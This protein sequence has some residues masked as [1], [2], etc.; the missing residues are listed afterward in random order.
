MIE[1][2]E[3]DNKPLVLV[4]GNWNRRKGFK[5][6]MPTPD[7]RIKILLENPAGGF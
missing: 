5:N 4:F 6:S 7:M 1:K 3:K 2:F